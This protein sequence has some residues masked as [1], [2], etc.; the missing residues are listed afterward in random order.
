M[1]PE[2]CEL[3]LDMSVRELSYQNPV[4]FPGQSPPA[5]KFKGLIR[6]KLLTIFKALSKATLRAI[7]TLVCYKYININYGR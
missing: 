5:N 2:P 3:D 1:E 6:A 4:Q 7:Q